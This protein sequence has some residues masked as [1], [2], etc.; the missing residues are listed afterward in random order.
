MQPNGIK[1]EK[2][3]FS[4]V[5]LIKQVKRNKVKSNWGNKKEIREY[6]HTHT[7][8]KNIFNRL[9]TKELKSDAKF[10]GN[11]KIKLWILMF[12][13]SFFKI[14]NEEHRKETKSTS[15]KMR[16]DWIFKAFTRKK[17]ENYEWNRKR[18][19]MKKIPNFSC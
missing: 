18:E 3:I 16:E 1:G 7:H 13:F 10:N 9:N 2:L 4:L 19:W 14:W 15:S 12:F 11:M 5:F 17:I 8:R 6:A